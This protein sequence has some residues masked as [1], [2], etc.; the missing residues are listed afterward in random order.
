MLEDVSVDLSTLSRTFG[1][2]VLALTYGLPI[3]DHDDP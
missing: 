2:L 3:R 1:G